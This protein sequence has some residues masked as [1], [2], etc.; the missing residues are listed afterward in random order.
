MIVA[1]IQP[2]ASHPCAMS[3]ASTCANTPPSEQPPASKLPATLATSHYP[4]LAGHLRPISASLS[5]PR[6]PFSEPLALPRH[7]SRVT[8]H[9]Q[10]QTE[11]TFQGWPSF[12]RVTVRGRWRSARLVAGWRVGA[13]RVLCSEVAGSVCGRCVAARG[14]GR[15]LRRAVGSVGACWSRPAVDAVKPSGSPPRQPKRHRPQSVSARSRTS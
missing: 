5:S 15:C 14:C 3:P 10:H 2:Y 13:V 12:P 1:H 9:A 6:R 7:Q 4:Q 8:R 11:G